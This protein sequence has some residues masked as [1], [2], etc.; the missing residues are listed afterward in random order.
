MS[1]PDQLL[2][3]TLAL[4]VAAPVAGAIMESRRSLAAVLVAAATASLA[5]HGLLHDAPSVVLVEA[6][7][8]LLA[9]IAA[10]AGGGA[11]CRACFPD[12]LDAVGAAILIGIAI[13]LG[14]FAAGPATG[15]LSTTAIDGALAANPI[16]AVSSALNIDILRGPLLYQLSPIAHR[17]F[18]YPTWWYAGALYAVAAAAAFLLASAGGWRG[19]AHLN[20]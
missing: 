13:T 6:H 14:L 15:L 1:V 17:Q 10:L 9:A 4:L 8:V 18:S 3:A 16:V 5:A 11:L 19:S 20:S 7:V 12:P 2:L